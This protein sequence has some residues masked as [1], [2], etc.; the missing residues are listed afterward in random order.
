MQILGLLMENLGFSF[1]PNSFYSRSLA[2]SI[3]EQNILIFCAYRKRA[4]SPNSNWGSVLGLGDLL[5]WRG[6][7][8]WIKINIAFAIYILFVIYPPLLLQSNKLIWNFQLNQLLQIILLL[9]L[10][11]FC[12]ATSIGKTRT[13]S[14]WKVCDLFKDAKW[15]RTQIKQ[16]DWGMYSYII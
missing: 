3:L 9:S 1:F 4:T 7:H 15:E 6:F 13:L 12:K 14:V 11:A 10:L 16:L 8:L 2:Y 5:L